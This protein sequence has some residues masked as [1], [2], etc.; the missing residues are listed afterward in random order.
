MSLL[1]LS[2]P[3]FWFIKRLYSTSNMKNEFK[4]IE[5]LFSWF[6]HEKNFKLESVRASS[7]LRAN[8]KRFLNSKKWFFF[9]FLPSNIKKIVFWILVWQV[10]VQHMNKKNLELHFCS[11]LCKLWA[12]TFRLLG[13]TSLRPFEQDLR[14]LKPTLVIRGW[15]LSVNM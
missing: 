5:L 15:S 3:L 13:S 6:F 9:H 1:N 7:I 10:S 14:V 4:K 2:R 8:V 11:E 12:W